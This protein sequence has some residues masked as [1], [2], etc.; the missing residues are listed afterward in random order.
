MNLILKLKMSLE[1]TPSTIPKNFNLY[2]ICYL[3]RHFS[4]FP[5]I[6]KNFEFM[7]K[8]SLQETSLALK[9]FPQFLI[10]IGFCG[11]VESVF[12]RDAFSINLIFFGILEGVSSRDTFH[13]FCI[14]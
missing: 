11:I 3:K 2:K 8:V 4:Q 9:S 13:T 12:S 7:L 5:Y 14:N 1:E 10:H 6:V